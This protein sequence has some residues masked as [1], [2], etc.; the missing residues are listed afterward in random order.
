MAAAGTEEKV[1][2]GSGDCG[3]EPPAVGT[4]TVADDPGLATVPWPVTVAVAGSEPTLVLA[5][6]RLGV[7]RGVA[8]ALGDG[9]ADSTTHMR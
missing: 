4:S 1:W 2:P 3:V 6:G 8:G 5:F 7:K 9:D